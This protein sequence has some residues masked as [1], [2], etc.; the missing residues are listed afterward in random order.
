MRH[1]HRKLRF[2]AGI[3]ANRM[4]LRKLAYNFIK[5]GKMIT[6]EKRA[7]ALRIYLETIVHKS[8]EETDA[9]KNFLLKKLGSPALIKVLYSQIG[10][11]VKEKSSGFV[12]IKRLHPRL[13]D[14]AAMTEIK[15]SMPVVMEEHKVEP[16]VGAAA[17]EVKAPKTVTKPRAAKKATKTK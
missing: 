8:K 4:M 16:V 5:S 14:G 10:P 1:G 15:W 2:G 6:T 13:S 3:D 17:S 11:A 9:N 7:K 12:T